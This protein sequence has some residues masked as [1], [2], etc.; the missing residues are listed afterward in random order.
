MQPSSK[1][2]QHS[3]SPSPHSPASTHNSSNLSA[4]ECSMSSNSTHSCYSCVGASKHA[5][6][7]LCLSPG[8]SSPGSPFFSSAPPMKIDLHSSTSRSSSRMSDCIARPSS[9]PFFPFPSNF[10]VMAPATSE[11]SVWAT[12]SNYSTSAASICV[13][14]DSPSPSSSDAPVLSLICWVQYD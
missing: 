4:A 7:H 11:E 3:S 1:K 13:I 6:C 14:P 8:Y 12:L 2:Q 5:N 9:P 10:R